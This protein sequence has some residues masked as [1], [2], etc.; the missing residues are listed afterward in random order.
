MSHSPVPIGK[1]VFLWFGEDIANLSSFRLGVL[2]GA[3]G[4]TRGV[5]L[6][7]GEGASPV[8]TSFD[9]VSGGAR[10]SRATESSRPMGRMGNQQG[11]C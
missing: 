4:L 11:L 7:S 6:N 9:H 10:W 1:S 8:N 5:L 2:R 3:G